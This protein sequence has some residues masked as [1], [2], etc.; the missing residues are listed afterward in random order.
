MNEKLKQLI[1][2][3]ESYPGAILVG[4]SKSVGP[5]EIRAG[6]QYGITHF[7]ENRVQDALAKISECNLG[8]KWHMIG[9]LQTNKLRKVVGQFFLIHSLCSLRLAEESSKVALAE[10][11]IFPFLVQVDVTGE[12]SKQGLSV[13]EVWPFLQ[14]VSVLPGV[15]IQGLMTIGPN[16]SDKVRIEKCFRRVRNLYD[17]LGKHAVAEVKMRYLSMGMSGDY[18]LALAAGSNMVRVGTAVFGNLK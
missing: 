6:Y 12:T 11:A 16:T 10:G 18:Q 13:E 9:R 3:I 1:A 2:E 7:G 14:A 4:V 15:S 8:I 17:E 5:Q